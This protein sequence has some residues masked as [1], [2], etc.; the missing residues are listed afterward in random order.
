MVPDP[1]N[2]TDPANPNNLPQW[3][4]KIVWGTNVVSKI[5]FTEFKN[6]LCP[7]WCPDPANN[8]CYPAKYEIK[9]RNKA[10]LGQFESVSA[11][12]NSFGFTAIIDDSL[13]GN[14]PKQYPVSIYTID[15][16]VIDKT[17]ECIISG[18]LANS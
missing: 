4:N 7:Q 3:G 6:D 2:P 15:P 18:H 17:Y 11:L 16:T 10:G 8:Q 1:L 13:T 5:H 14:D 12:P 9:C